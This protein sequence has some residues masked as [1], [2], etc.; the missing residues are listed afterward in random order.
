MD[1]RDAHCPNRQLS[2]ST[3]WRTGHGLVAGKED[4]VELDYNEQFIGRLSGVEYEGAPAQL[5][6][7]DTQLFLC[8][9][10]EAVQ[11]RRLAASL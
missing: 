7:L 9:L 5:K 10:R 8:K 4:P 3:A 1:Q 11:R 6:H 2:E